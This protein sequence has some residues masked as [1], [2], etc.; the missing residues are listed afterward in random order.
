MIEYRRAM[1]F[2]ALSHPT[3]IKIMRLVHEKPRSF[4]ELKHELGLDSS[5]NLQH[6]MGKLSGLVEEDGKYV[7]TDLGVEALKLVEDSERPGTSLESLCSSSTF[8]VSDVHDEMGNGP[9]RLELDHVHIKFRDHKRTID[10][11][12]ALGF[13]V[14]RVRS[15]N[16]EY[17]FIALNRGNIAPSDSTGEKISIGVVVN[18]LDQVYGLAK[19][20][21]VD[22]V[23]DIKDRPWGPR[24]FHVKD[25]NG[26]VIEFEQASGK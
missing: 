16:G 22:I 15:E 19:E 1:V 12:E 9:V 26:Y 7:L 4:A 2:E 17:V 25:P 6:H 13:K 24:S 5:G 8:P 10:F 3:R 14:R 23:D 18:R 20:H 21:G 11:Y